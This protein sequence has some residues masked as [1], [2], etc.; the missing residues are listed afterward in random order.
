MRSDDYASSHPS[1]R[2]LHPHEETLTHGVTIGKNML[3]LGLITLT[4]LMM[5]TAATVWYFAFR[6]DLAANLIAKQTQMQYAYED[7]VSA[8]RTRL[9]RVA[10]QKLIEQDGLE[11][12]VADILNR[13]VQL[14]T[15]QAMLSALSDQA[16]I[17]AT[18]N[19]QPATTGSIRP[20]PRDVSPKDPF[21]VKDPFAID[22]QLPANANSYAPL[23]VSKPTPA[24]DNAPPLRMR[25]LSRL[26]DNPPPLSRSFLTR[27]QDMPAEERL[28]GVDK[29]LRMVDIAQIRSLDGLARTAQR[30]A[31]IYRQAVVE[32]GLNPDQLQT[33]KQAGLAQ[34]GIGGPFVP[35]KIDSKAGTFEALVDR[36]Q[37]NIII[38]DR[39][40]RATNALPF[41]R[42]MP[43]GTDISSTFGYRVDPFTRGL[44]MHTGIDFRAEHGAPTRATGAGRVITADASG[45]YGNMV[46][47]D[48][49][50]GVTSR[51]A[52]LSSIDVVP[53]QIIKA[54]AI[55]GRVGSTGRSTGPHL[56]YETRIHGEAVDPHRFLRAGTRLSQR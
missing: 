22:S 50:N 4:L 44:A 1:R 47:I 31:E 34:T 54:G 17:V 36:L 48:H 51:Y 43:S 2:R 20:A 8:L 32:T 52:H 35:I 39:L 45:G 3:A 26:E 24:L 53:G 25:G 46:E 21:A 9:D 13:Q 23:P 19:P 33:P 38:L 29:S 41:S 7:K 10:S 14:E 40:R 16:G 30:K 15:R 49:G 28:M 6:D 18:S 12:R 37:G 5:W 42:P 56:H 11:G 55:I 27:L